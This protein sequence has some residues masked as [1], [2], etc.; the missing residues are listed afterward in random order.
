MRV[1]D[2]IPL[3]AFLFGGVP[4]RD[5]RPKR[6]KP[7]RDSSDGNVI[8]VLIVD[9]GTGAIRFESPPEATEEPTE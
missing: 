7:P 3:E 5:R 9:T 8:E 4:E 6:T 2:L 1:R